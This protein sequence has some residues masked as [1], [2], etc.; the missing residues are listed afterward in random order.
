VEISVTG[1]FVVE[2]ESGMDQLVLQYLTVEQ[3][4]VA[5]AAA[6]ASAYGSTVLINNVIFGPTSGIHMYAVAD[7]RIIVNGPYTISGGAAVHAEAARGGYFE[8]SSSY[9]GGPIAI[10]LSGT[11][12]FSQ[13]RL[14]AFRIYRR[15]RQHIHRHRDRTARS[16]RFEWHDRH[17]RRG[18]ELFPR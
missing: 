11:P 4:G 12:N 1:C 5:G 2:V 16:R 13:F 10:T 8:F 6:V 3:T 7:G 17:R 14:C 18:C 15:R 9:S